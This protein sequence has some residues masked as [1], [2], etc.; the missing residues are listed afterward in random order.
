MN[1][2][3]K[4]L[5][6]EHKANQDTVRAIQ[7]DVS[8]GA[9]PNKWDYKQFRGQIY[10]MK[11]LSLTVNSL[12]TLYSTVITDIINP[13]FERVV[14]ASHGDAS[15]QSTSLVLVAKQASMN[16]YLKQAE[17]ECKNK[18]LLA[19]QMLNARLAEV[20]ADAASAEKRGSR[21]RSSRS[22]APSFRSSRSSEVGSEKSKGRF[23]RRFGR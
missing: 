7:D 22:A 2:S 19:N 13:G 8:A 12:S 18:S 9:N 15:G 3:I 20:D 14:E 23:S 4:R 1:D 21:R 17:E 5:V 16:S 10:Q 11:R 6:E